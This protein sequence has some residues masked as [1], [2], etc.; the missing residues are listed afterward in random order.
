MSVVT[1]NLTVKK[2]FKDYFMSFLI[3]LMMM[4]IGLCWIPLRI[5]GLF[6]GK[7]F[8]KALYNFFMLFNKDF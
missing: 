2:F 1:E 5:L 4:T 6:F 3:F 8:D 7:F